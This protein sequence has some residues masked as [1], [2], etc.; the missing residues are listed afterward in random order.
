LLSSSK[1]RN[2]RNFH[3]AAEVEVLKGLVKKGGSVV[4]LSDEL[5]CID[6]AEIASQTCPAQRQVFFCFVFFVATKKMKVLA[7]PRRFCFWG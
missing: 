1:K 5:F 7:A 4:A 3:P 6:V 2:S